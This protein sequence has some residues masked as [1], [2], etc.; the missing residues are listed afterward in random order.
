MTKEKSPKNN[1][2]PSSNKPYKVNEDQ[3]GYGK[4]MVEA[5]KWHTLT[6]KKK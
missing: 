4:A 5:L 1:T 3:G 2:K 6:M